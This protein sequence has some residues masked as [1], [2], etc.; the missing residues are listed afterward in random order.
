MSTA[1]ANYGNWEFLLANALIEPDADRLPAR[2]SAADKDCFHQFPLHAP[3]KHQAWIGFS[4]LLDLCRSRR[5]EK[6]SF[7]QSRISSWSEV[8]TLEGAWP[9]PRRTKVSPLL[10]DCVGQG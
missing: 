10:T 1:I 2:I 8:R 9:T 6:N 7:L 3:A 5:W 4:V